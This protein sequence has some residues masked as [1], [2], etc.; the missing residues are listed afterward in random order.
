MRKALVLAMVTVVAGG[1][2]GGSKERGK[3]HPGPEHAK[4]ARG[5]YAIRIEK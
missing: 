3:R 5:V 2:G 1:C 4:N